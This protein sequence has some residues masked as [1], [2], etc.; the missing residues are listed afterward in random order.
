MM[1]KLS[2][3]PKPPTV[4]DTDEDDDDT[5]IDAMFESP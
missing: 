4:P 2:H 3:A 1:T 5:E